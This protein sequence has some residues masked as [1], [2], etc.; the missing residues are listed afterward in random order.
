MSIKLTS[1]NIHWFERFGQLK[2]CLLA[3]DSNLFLSIEHIGSTS[4]PG[5][6]A[7]DIIDV[8]CGIKSFNLIPK[9]EKHLASIGFKKIDN[10]NQDHIPFKT[11]K[12]FSKNWE[13]RL[14]KGNYKNQNYNLHVRLYDSSNW[15][16][17]LAFKHYLIKNTQ[18][19]F[20]YAQ[21]KQRLVN[22]NLDIEHYCLIKDSFID[23]L[24]LNFD[25][26]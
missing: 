21:L 15:K 2:Q 26:L 23:A 1:F 9:L 14:F 11:E 22:A 7:K 24:S 18:A 5:M 12:V 13:K 10:I 4:I 6:M 20:A 25:Q 16:F 17:A 3:L 8:Q 19:R